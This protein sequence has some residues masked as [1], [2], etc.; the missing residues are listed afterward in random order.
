MFRE[1]GLGAG[2]GASRDH[3]N[4]APE[5]L[6]GLECCAKDLTLSSGR[7]GHCLGMV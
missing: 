7:I 5:G 6:E 4:Q 3:G 2:A 1:Q